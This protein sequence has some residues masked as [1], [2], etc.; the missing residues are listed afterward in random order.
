MPHELRRVSERQRAVRLA[1]HYRD[2]EGLPI[3]E[4]AMRLGRSRATVRG[5]LYDP[6]G[7]RARQ[8]KERYR[9]QCSRC[10]AQTS[11]S[12]PGQPKTVC[13]RCNGRA[14]AKWDRPAI[15]IAL[16]AWLELYGEPATSTD[17]SLSYARRR[18]S[19]GDGE[20]LRR[21]RDGWDGGR[22]PAASVV[23]YHYKT[24]RSANEQALAS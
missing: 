6:H 15:E 3:A 23:Q 7:I 9:G 13:A 21:L 16:R 14:S 22:W 24:V 18:A 4:I 2:T 17:L 12:G 20:R 5:Y 19:S 1:R 8:V 10:A 11:G